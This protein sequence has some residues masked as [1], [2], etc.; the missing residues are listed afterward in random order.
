MIAGSVEAALGHSAQAVERYEAALAIH[1]DFPQ[2]YANLA[3]L[4]RALGQEDKVSETLSRGLVAAP[5]DAALHYAKGLHLVRIGR[6]PLGLAEIRRAVELAPDDAVYA[7]GYAV[8]LYSA[9]NKKPAFDFLAA[10]LRDHPNDRN[11]LY[12]LAH[13][14]IEGGRPGVLA[15]YRSRLE[16]LAAEDPQA[17]QLVEALRPQ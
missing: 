8:G 15:P 11:S 5:N 7:Y 14:A 12:L 1:A 3:D 13:I 17:R 4:Y 9:H 2:A 10:R 6:Q 16:Q